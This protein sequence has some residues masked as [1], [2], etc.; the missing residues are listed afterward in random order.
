MSGCANSTRPDTSSSPASTAGPAAVRSRTRISAA[1]CRRS[2]SPRGSAAAASTSSCVSLGSGWRRL[3]KLCSILLATRLVRGKPNPPAT[4]VTFQVRGSSRSASGLPWLSLMSCSQTAASRGPCRFSSSRARASLSPRLPTG[5][6]GSPLRT[7]SPSPVRAA[8]TRAIRSAR[9]RRATNETICAEAAS[10]HCASSIRQRSGCS[11]GCLGQQGQRGE[12]DQESIGRRSGLVPEDRGQRARAAVREADRGD[13]ASGNTT[14]AARCMRAPSPTRCRPP[15]RCASRY[16]ARPRNRAAS[17]SRRRPRRA[18]R[19]HGSDR[20]TRRPR[21]CRGTRTRH[22]V[23]E[24]SSPA[25]PSCPPWPYRTPRS[26][27]RAYLSQESGDLSTA[28]RPTSTRRR[29]RHFRVGR[30]GLEPATLGLKVPYLTSVASRPLRLF[31]SASGLAPVSYRGFR[32]LPRTPVTT[33]DQNR[34]TDSDRSKLGDS[35]EVH[36]ILPP[37]RSR[38]NAAT[39]SR[40]LSAISMC[41]SSKTCSTPTSTISP[42]CRFTSTRAGAS[43]PNSLER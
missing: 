33:R 11:F 39:W 27:A 18:G 19:R 21:P 14:G 38:D 4:S 13:P 5:S 24:A 26:L 41:S 15:S 37:A 8:Q 1:R 9:N 43:R 25:A 22:L 42:S 28:C 17:S 16:H 34:S 23:H 2:G 3:A 10:S 7:S 12:P 31:E 20:R 40:S 29:C 35:N 6:V 36:E 30:A 32:D